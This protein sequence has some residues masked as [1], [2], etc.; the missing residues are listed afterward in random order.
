MMERF[1]LSV[2]D[3]LRN[4]QYRRNVQA[5]VSDGYAAAAANLHYAMWPDT[6]DVG[7]RSISLR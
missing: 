4:G 6:I 5:Q 1:G 3:A 2:D 7:D